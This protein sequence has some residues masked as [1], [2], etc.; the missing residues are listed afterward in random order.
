METRALR[1]QIEG[2]ATLPTIPSVLR[3]IL[4]VIEDPKISLKEIGSFISSDP[5]LASRVLKVVNS[6]IY[7]FSGRIASVNQALLLLGLN[8]VR[9][10]LFGVSVFE[11][12]EKSM[13]GLWAHSLGCAVTARIIAQKKGVEEP[14]EVSV[15]ALLHDIGKVA[16]HLKFPE[17]Y[18]EVLARAE[19]EELFIT[20]AE[21][22]HFSVHHARPGAW[23]AEKWNFPKNLVEMIGY[24]H[25]P[26]LARNVPVQTAIVHLSD[27][28]IRARGFGFA[29]DRFVPPVQPAAWELLNLSDEE[30]KS[31][32]GEI[33]EGLVRAEDFLQ[34][35]E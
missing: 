17:E 1:S 28:I 18:A 4:R 5:V 22:R 16:L 27:I 2:I 31:I 6:P 19:A 32:L 10:M 9:G 15:A 26:Q 33:D 3:T 7:G 30:M 12:M 13:E 8:V 14:E 21:E 29:G 25:Q 11:V 23:I 20:V 35:D 24:H 34:F